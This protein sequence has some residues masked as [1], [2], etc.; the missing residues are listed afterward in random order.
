M[1]DGGPGADAAGGLAAASSPVAASPVTSLMKRLSLGVSP[2]SATP[3]AQSARGGTPASRGRRRSVRAEAAQRK[4]DPAVT[5][6]HSLLGMPGLI[7]EGRLIGAPAMLPILFTLLPTYVANHPATTSSTTTVTFHANPAHN[8][9]RS[10][11][12]IFWSSQYLITVTTFCANPQ[13][14]FDSLPLTSLASRPLQSF[15]RSPTWA[16]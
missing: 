16:A 6:E 3:S 7:E 5:P 12:H 2:S 15:A 4:F 8:L 9:T 10:P 14:A 1:E 13:L 11:V